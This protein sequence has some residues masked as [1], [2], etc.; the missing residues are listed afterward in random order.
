MSALLLVPVF[1]LVGL[2]SVFSAL[3][4]PVN[5]E[6]EISDPVAYNVQTAPILHA[7]I[8][9]NPHVWQGG[10]IIVDEDG[11]LVPPS[12]PAANTHKADADGE[13]SQYV[14]REGDSLSAIADMFGVS[15]NTILWASNIKNRN[16]IRPGDTLVILPI[17][18][19]SH[20]VKKGDSLK[21]IADKY[22]GDIAD[23][24]AY[25][26]LS[27]ESD[28]Q[29]GA[30]VVIPGGEVAPPPPPKETL[31]PK[32]AK[33]GKKVGSGTGLSTSG[34]NGNLVN[35]APGA[36]KTQGIHGHNGVD[37]GG[38]EGT[39]VRAA[40]AGTVILSRAEG[41]NGGYGKYIVIK[42]PNGTQTLYAHLSQDSVQVGEKVSQGEH[43]GAIGNTGHSTGPH[44]HF[45]VRGGRNPF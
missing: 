23:I 39:E 13:I 17:S 15:M 42:H 4:T 1:A 38:P 40:A 9:A 33:S 11:V 24:V 16:T 32:T 45:E 8:N 27:G 6:G 30:T 12:G 31:K 28:I 41:Y 43:I 37:L 29:P 26:Q 44:L 36:I 22:N 35:P 20:V 10:D 14:V 21:S 2:L 25:N 19:V 34:G 3:T 7:P 18:G 5:A